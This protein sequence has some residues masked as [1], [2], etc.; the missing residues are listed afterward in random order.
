MREQNLDQCGFKLSLV[1]QID[2]L[3]KGIYERE[4]SN[5]SDWITPLSN[6]NL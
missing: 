1:S 2:W 6:L 3:G 4:S 5:P